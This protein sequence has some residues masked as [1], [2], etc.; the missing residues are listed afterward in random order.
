MVS[1][2]LALIALLWCVDHSK[3]E[4][5]HFMT[6]TP[7][8][9]CILPAT[10]NY[11]GEAI[12][13]RCI[14]YSLEIELQELSPPVPHGHSE[15]FSLKSIKGIYIPAKIIIPCQFITDPLKSLRIIFHQ[16]LSTR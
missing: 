7:G 9:I 8:L 16:S 2:Y 13:L 6:N 11:L 3:G 15:Q 12:L 14:K 1:Q 4:N 10:Y 5:Y